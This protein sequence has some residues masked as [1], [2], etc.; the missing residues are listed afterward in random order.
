MITLRWPSAPHL[1]HNVLQGMDPA[2][3]VEAVEHHPD[4]GEQAKSVQLIILVPIV[5]QG[6]NHSQR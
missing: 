3:E 6:G 4:D 1:G 5:Y 2:L